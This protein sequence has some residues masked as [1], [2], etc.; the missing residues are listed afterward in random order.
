MG[1]LPLFLYL[2]FVPRFM[3]RLGQR[4]MPTRNHDSYATLLEVGSALWEPC[5]NAVCP[6]KN[7]SGGHC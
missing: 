4:E 1:C 2:A 5:V 6:G 7:T 3:Q